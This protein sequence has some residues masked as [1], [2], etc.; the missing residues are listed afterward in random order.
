MPPDNRAFPAQIS[1]DLTATEERVFGEP[2][3]DLF[4]QRQ[5]VR[6]DANRRVVE[7]RPAKTYQLALLANAQLGMITRF[8]PGLIASALRAKNHS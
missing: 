5:Y 7:S 1:G 8:F 2:P 4:H 3:V 6:F